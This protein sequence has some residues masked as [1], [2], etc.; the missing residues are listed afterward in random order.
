MPLLLDSGFLFVFE[1]VER[2]ILANKLHDVP[3]RLQNVFLLGVQGHRVRL[4]I[5]EGDVDHHRVV[6]QAMKTLDHVKRVGMRLAAVTK[7]RLI[8]E[9]CSVDD[10]RVSLPM[11]NGVAHP[12]G[13][14]I[15]DV[16]A[17]IREDLTNDMAV[18][19]KH[20]HAPRSVNNLERVEEQ[21]D[22]RHAGREAL[23][24]GIVR[25]YRRSVRSRGPI[26]FE[27]LLP[28]CGQRQRTLQGLAVG[29]EPHE[30]LAGIIGSARSQSA[31][32]RRIPDSG[33]VGWSLAC[34]LASGRSRLRSLRA[35]HGGKQ[36]DASEKQTDRPVSHLEE[37]RGNPM[38][39]VSRPSVKT[40]F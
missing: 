16:A 29:I 30:L 34:G 22:P 38:L 12:G 25:V 36:E 9:P 5:V 8:V 1:E 19:E 7:P 20:E 10:Q 6:V 27:F 21:I 26:G 24:I 23:K 32:R 3:I 11:A 13:F 17:A 15:L 35:R 37:S 18:L 31:A 14:R 2:I 4:G 33:K 39:G 28:P 40:T